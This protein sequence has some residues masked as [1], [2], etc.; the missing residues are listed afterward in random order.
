MTKEDFGYLLE[1]TK[2]MTYQDKF[3]VVRAYIK[4]KKNVDYQPNQV[5]AFQLDHAFKYAFEYY[6][7]KFN[8][9]TLRS[10]GRDVNNPGRVIKYYI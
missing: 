10:R 7:N 3:E 2:N 4:E 9:Y 6:M 1:R 5:D 8:A